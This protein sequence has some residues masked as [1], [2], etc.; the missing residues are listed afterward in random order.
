MAAHLGLLQRAKAFGGGAPS[1]R[2]RHA[3]QREIP[4][5][6]TGSAD[7]LALVNALLQR[8]LS[9][10]SL[11]AD[12][13]RPGTSPALPAEPREQPQPQAVAQAMAQLGPYG[14]YFPGAGR[15]AGPG[16][17][18][19]STALFRAGCVAVICACV[20][21]PCTPGCVHRVP[22]LPTACSPAAF[23]CRQSLLTTGRHGSFT[24]DSPSLRALLGTQG[25]GAG[26]TQSADGLVGTEAGAAN[27]HGKERGAGAASGNGDASGGAGTRNG[28]PGASSPSPGPPKG[29]TK[30][31]GAGPGPSLSG[32]TKAALAGH[33]YQMPAMAGPDAGPRPA[34]SVLPRSASQGPLTRGNSR[35]RPSSATLRKAPSGPSG[36]AGADS[37]PL[38]AST[39]DGRASARAGPAG[40]PVVP[41]AGAVVPT[42]RDTSGR[43]SAEPSGAAEAPAVAA[44]QGARAA[45]RSRAA[46]AESPWPG[47]SSTQ[48]LI[49]VVDQASKREKEFECEL[50]TLTRHMRYFETYLEGVDLADQV[51]ISVFC[52]VGEQSTLS[53]YWRGCETCCEVCWLLEEGPIRS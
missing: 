2:T 19:A 43:S 53:W 17:P 51:E 47:A 5:E 26:P 35:V 36:V 38:Q 18:P 24:K 46:G 14:K 44:R 16:A 21:G 37:L 34:G 39:G 4:R 6:A 10:A 29:A 20:L 41:A 1:L 15:V 28:A 8:R 12:A 49:H 13:G 23:L 48:A 45:E 30:A 31:A 33:V 27:G 7:P 25:N 42:S 3:S 50:A 11:E 9:A 32:P 52:D 22:A 40:G